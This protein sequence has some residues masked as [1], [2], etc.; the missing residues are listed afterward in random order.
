MGLKN[1][2]GY[3]HNS[4]SHHQS[5]RYYFNW[6]ISSN[7][8]LSLKSQQYQQLQQLEI[9]NSKDQMTFYKAIE[10]ELKIEQIEVLTNQQ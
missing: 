8:K 10:I 2:V 9:S 6:G 3:I 5:D 7:E 4:L 1:E